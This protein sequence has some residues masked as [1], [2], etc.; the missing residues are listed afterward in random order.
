MFSYIK[1]SPTLIRVVPFAVFLFLTFTQEQFGV[2]G[3]YWIYLIKSVVGGVMIV[4]LRAGLPEIRW[5]FSWAALVVGTGVFGVWVGFDSFYPRLHLVYPEYVCPALD[6]IGIVNECAAASTRTAW[7]PHEVFGRDSLLSN[8]FV[9]VRILGSTIV[10]PPMEEMF[11]RSFVYRYLAKKDFLSVPLDRILPFPF[12]LTSVVFGFVHDEWLAGI[13]CGLAYQGL[14]VWKGR[15]GDAIFAHAVTNC[16][17]G[18]W[19]ASRGAW[20]FW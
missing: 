17:L 10:V 20:H 2:V 1:H 7:N 16:L 15:L 4:A 12:L 19:V 5:R 6:R 3:R 8:F 9:A 18:I 11:Y 14:V 13:F